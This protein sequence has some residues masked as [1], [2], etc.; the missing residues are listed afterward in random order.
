MQGTPQGSP[1]A[2]AR[3][4]R[5]AIRIARLAARLAPRFVLHDCPQLLFVDQI[6]GGPVAHKKM[7]KPDNVDSKN[8][9]TATAK[10]LHSIYRYLQK[11]W[12][13]R[14]QDAPSI[15]ARTP[16][17]YTVSTGIYKNTG[18]VD[19]NTAGAHVLCIT[20]RLQHILFLFASM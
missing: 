8:V 19:T 17:I 18:I 11:R 9:D 1:C 10:Y 20:N 5:P 13:C 6:S 4:A 16:S 2:L 12:T 14:Y 15:Y 7:L 3:K